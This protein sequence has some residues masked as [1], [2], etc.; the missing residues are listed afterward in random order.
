MEFSELQHVRMPPSCPSAA[1]VLEQLQ[2][3][4]LPWHIFER[5]DGADIAWRTREL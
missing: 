4:F 5:F 3:L 2:S 1:C